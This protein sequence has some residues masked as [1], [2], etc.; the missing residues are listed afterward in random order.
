[1]IYTK[2]DDFINSIFYD[3]N[4]NFNFKTLASLLIGILLGM[5]IAASIYGILLLLSIKKSKKNFNIINE[6]DDELIETIKL[7]KK[8]YINITSGFSS[9]EKV[10]VLGNTIVNTI[11]TVALRYYPNSK[12]PLYEL[13][14]D[15]LIVLAHYITNR[16]DEVFDKN[17]LK[18][19]RGVSISQV[20]KILDIH[21]KVKENKAIKVAKKVN[22]AMKVLK[23]IA[24]FANPAHWIKKLIFGGTLQ[25]AINQMSLIVIDIVASETTKVYSK[26]LFNEENKMI[27]EIINQEIKEM[28]ELE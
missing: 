24:N 6:I 14:I 3:L 23:G 17:I 13:N 27:D 18:H 22:P 15:E 16:I 26:R 1:M 2:I 12:Y 9:S 10:K 21:K 8:D 4:G 5:F 25:L 20:F 19:L 28:E 7:I 11:K